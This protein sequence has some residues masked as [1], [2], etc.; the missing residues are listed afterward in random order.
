VDT[1]KSV[2]KMARVVKFPS[3]REH[4]SR[5]HRHRYDARAWLAPRRAAGTTPGGASLA[6]TCVI[7]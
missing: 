5:I 4:V 1:C 2:T 7:V 6:R 3:A